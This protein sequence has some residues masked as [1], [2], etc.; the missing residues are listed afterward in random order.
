MSIYKR[1]SKNKTG[2]TTEY[3]YVEISLP[4]GRK[5]KRSV[6]KVGQVTKA[7]ARQ[8][9][10][11]H[12]KKLRLGQLEMIEAEIPTLNEIKDDYITY[13]RDVSKKRSWKRD[14][15]LLKP[16]CK[17]FG[18]KKLSD[19]NT[20]DIENFK[21]AR[22]KEVSPATVNR[23]LSVL[24]HLFNLA[25]KWKK[26]FGD[27]PV[28]LAG[29]LQENNQIERIL[30][31]E[32][33]KRLIES[34]SNHLRPIIITA[35]NTG[36]RRGEILGLRWND[37]DLDNNLITITQTNSKSKRQRKV[38]INSVLRKQLAKLKLKSGGNDYVFL[39]NKGCQ[40]PGIR[41]TF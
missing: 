8:V 7:V 28:S 19:I 40:A 30:S 35:L 5:I 20:K 22:L 25:K 41:S 26:F 37:V 32:E 24:K 14:E 10:S 12:K 27:N 39:S 36:M 13:V 38:P 33:E 16:L 9:E 11:E 6:G 4:G 17:L 15:E 18:N 31:L 21:L 1:K 2:K 29:M 23:S 3:W 34:S